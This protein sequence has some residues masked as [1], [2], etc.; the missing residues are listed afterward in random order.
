[1][2]ERALNLDESLIDA[3]NLICRIASQFRFLAC[4][5]NDLTKS[6]ALASCKDG[7]VEMS[8]P[9]SDGMIGWSKSSDRG[10]RGSFVA[11]L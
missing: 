9:A 4:S 3:L 1:M 2:A 10:E 6:E 7:D 5:G 11:D 8:V